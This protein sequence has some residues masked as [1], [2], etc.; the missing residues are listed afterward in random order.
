VEDAE[1][2]GV[3]DQLAGQLAIAPTRGLARTKEAIYS[4]GSR[5]LEQQLDVERDFQRELGFSAD[6]AEGVSAFTEKRAPRFTGR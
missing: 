1:L 2:A 6:Y 4:S 3:V 5:T